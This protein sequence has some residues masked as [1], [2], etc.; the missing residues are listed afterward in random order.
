V[1]RV[2][3]DSLLSWPRTISLDR[4]LADLA[5][6]GVQAAGQSAPLKTD[7]STIICSQVPSLLI[8]IDGEPVMKSLE[9][10]GRHDIS[11]SSNA[12]ALILLDTG[13]SRYYP[14]GGNLWMAA[15]S[16]NFMPPDA[17]MRSTMRSGSRPRT[18]WGLG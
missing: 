10:K 15:T 13:S 2:V 18:P 1:E 14:D 8:L 4:H 9:L 3:R 16:L 17:A 5:I 11:A 6:T 12:P 7:P